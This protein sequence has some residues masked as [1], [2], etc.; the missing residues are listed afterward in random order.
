[1]VRSKGKTNIK[2]QL[3]FLGCVFI[4]AFLFFAKP[5]L[6]GVII[7]DYE[8]S[9][10]TTAGPNNQDY[11]MNFA[12]ATSGV[13]IFHWRELT[14]GANGCNAYATG[15]PTVFIDGVPFEKINTTD[16]DVNGYNYYLAYASTTIISSASHSLSI[17]TIENPAGGQT[18]TQS[19][20]L[21]ILD[22]II[23]SSVLAM[24]LDRGGE[25]G[26]A[27]DYSFTNI[28]T[29][30]NPDGLKGLMMVGTQ[31]DMTSF[32]GTSSMT[33]INDADATMF[34]FYR[35]IPALAQG[36]YDY[37]WSSFSPATYLYIYGIL[38]PIDTTPPEP[39]APPQSGTLI[40]SWKNTPVGCEDVG[41]ITPFY[42]APGADGF[43]YDIFASSSCAGN[44][45]ASG[46]YISYLGGVFDDTVYLPPPRTWGAATYCMYAHLD[47]T[48]MITD[49]ENFS[50][51]WYASTSDS[52]DASILAQQY[53]TYCAYP[54]YGIA[55]S[56]N[57]LD[58]NNFNC[59]LRKFGCWLTVVDKSTI[60]AFGNRYQAII[61]RFPLAPVTRLV[62]DLTLV[63]TGTQS[64]APGVLALPM[65][66]TSTGHYV[67]E[68]FDVGSSTW[69]HSYGNVKWRR[70]ADLA[71][72]IF[73]CVL[74]IVGTIILLIL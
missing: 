29:A 8:G 26:A 18:C 6:A 23:A 25:S 69:S 38:F 19:F 50:V 36:R 48:P 66:S 62:D 72:W 73:L 58:L 13:A 10:T 65:W 49:Y 71:M 5:V 44:E 21:F 22:D 67:G 2:A 40:D 63:S 17:D 39:P 56:T 54:C 3:T 42:P 7:Y 51:N 14:S 20:N 32:V 45:V 61:R 47:Q 41:V 37:G 57:P 35:N 74:P 16:Q 28:T 12:T 27:K 43:N 52:C 9:W 64:V 59:G 24:T 34:S 53:L 31:A 30:K 60:D 33:V 15:N 46:T 55:T 1:M 4:F 68:N 70:F 11:S